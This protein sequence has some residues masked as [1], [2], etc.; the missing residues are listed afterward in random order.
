VIADFQARAAKLKATG[1][2][3]S[4]LQESWLFVIQSLP[5]EFIPAPF[6]LESG[7]WMQNN[8]DQNN[9]WLHKPLSEKAK[10]LIAQ[11]N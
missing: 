7:K 2:K 11:T 4:R 8:I 6:H 10:R 5:A 3:L 9:L 1:F